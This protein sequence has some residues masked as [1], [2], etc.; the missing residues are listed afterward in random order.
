VILF[1]K[2][3]RDLLQH[4]AQFISI[5]LISLLAVGF[6]T[7]ITAEY[8]SMDTSARTFFAQTHLA[9]VWAFGADFTEDDLATIEAL[10]G[11]EKAE[12]TLLYETHADLPA[13]P[14]LPDDAATPGEVASPALTLHYRE[15]GEVNALLVWDGAAFDVDDERIW[16][17]RRF[18]EERLLGVGDRL[19]FTV[20]GV[21]V[22]AQIAGLVYSPELVGPDL[23]DTL[24]PDFGAQGHVYTGA[25]NFPARE[26][27][28]AAAAEAAGDGA[29]AAGAT[30]PAS[31]A[32]EAAAGAAEAPP[33]QSFSLPY[34]Q[35]AVYAPAWDSR[36][37]EL[38][39]AVEGALGKK[40]A[41]LTTQQDHPTW[42]MLQNECEQHAIFADVFPVL[43]MFIA[44]LV[45]LSTMSRLVRRQSTLIGTMKALGV[46]KGAIT[47]HYI[48]YGFLITLTG[49]LLGAALG[50]PLVPKLFLPSM[51]RYFTLPGYPT[52][53]EPFFYLLPLL[54][55]LAG[56]L[57]SWLSS[58][59]ILAQKPAAAMRPRAPRAARHSPL[60]AL[61]FWRRLGPNIQL[62]ERDIRRN[63]LRSA[64]SL[65]S[66][67]GTSALLVVAFLSWSTV[68]DLV[69]W[70]YGTINNF[71]S[72]A[73]LAEDA[74]DE[75]RRELTERYEATALMEAAI[76]L[77]RPQETSTR[78]TGTLQVFEGS[79]AEGNALIRLTDPS[80]KF[81]SLEDDTVYLSYAAAQSLGLEPGERLEWCLYGEGD[82]LEATVGVINRNPM[83]QGL[84]MTPQTLEG[85]G[86]D[87]EP[88]SIVS[89]QMIDANAP[90]IQSV[91][92]AEEIARGMDLM[93]DALIMMSLVMIAAAV[94]IGIFTMYNLG[95]LTFSEMERELATLKVMGFR[96]R[97]IITLLSSQNLLL[98]LL[99]LLGGLPLGWLV[100]D[101]MFKAT[102]G[103]FDLPVFFYPSTVALTLAVIVALCLFVSLLFIR[104]VSRLDMVRSLKSSE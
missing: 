62:N 45:M 102:G 49:G 17:D 67:M 48:G 44:V 3:W 77:R 61:P 32:A 19:A 11:V 39:A 42:T 13:L 80:R 16:L 12:R 69:S 14:A 103:A 100:T 74:D 93:T 10:E 63:R 23:D 6:Y 50:P 88:T 26:I 35:L 101:L 78:I 24:T 92:G 86:I 83:V 52:Y 20:E 47:A 15:G 2:M 22:E 7:G 97:Q 66:S 5:F 36:Q 81:I 30:A 87:F 99:G 25:E 76:E 41:T 91:A 85:F 95:T 1:K 21:R 40:A 28:E 34:N 38:E 59:H 104:K 53:H 79:G 54:M 46:R 9:T 72:R 43:F 89:A 82:W 75:Q 71:A 33:S 73:V 68:G 37:D 18:A 90:A 55:A 60:E 29:E 94:L 84:T 64:M 57:V 70:Q 4:K 31:G 58:R 27:A 96:R 98:S 8:R 65:I 56:A 51:T